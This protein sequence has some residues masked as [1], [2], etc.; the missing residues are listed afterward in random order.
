M[1]TWGNSHRLKFHTGVTFD[2]I[3]PVHVCMFFL[4]SYDQDDDPILNWRKLPM[5]Y[6]FQFTGRPISHRNKWS[7]RVYMIPL[8]NFVREWNSRSG[9]TTGVNSRRGDSRRHDISLL[10][11]RRRQTSV[12]ASGSEITAR[13]TSGCRRCE[14]SRRSG[15]VCNVKAILPSRVKR[16]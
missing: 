13:K 1:F 5:R 9:T 16:E 8:R 15:L 11:I 3:I 6:P 10:K 12:T 7:F 4:S 2:F 14:V